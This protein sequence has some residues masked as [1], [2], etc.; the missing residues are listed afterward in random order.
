MKQANILTHLSAAIVMTIL[1]AFIYAAVQQV[2]RSTANDPQ[3]QLSRDIS[4]KISQGGPIDKWFDTDT[5]NISQSL[6]V[7]KTLYNYNAEPVISTGLLNGKKPSLP[8]GVFDFAKSTGENVFTWQP[9]GGVRVAVVIKSIHSPV[10]S[11]VAV[12]RS[13]LEVEKRESNLLMMAVISWL[14]C[15]GLIMLHWLVSFIETKTT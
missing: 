4:D 8:K 12:G 2:H 15:V 13:L 9:E 7:F 3:L 1:V 14:L 5:I 6:G 11:F 10:Y